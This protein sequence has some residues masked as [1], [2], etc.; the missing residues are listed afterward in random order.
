M[1]SPENRSNQKMSDIFLILL[2]N[3]FFIIMD[4]PWI[5]IVLGQAEKVQS[6]MKK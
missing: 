6:R 2:N 1:S 3:M 4:S 5:V